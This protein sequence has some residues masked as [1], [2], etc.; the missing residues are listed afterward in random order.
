LATDLVARGLDIPAVKTVI[1]FSFPTE[2]KRYLHRVGRTARAGANGVAVTLCNDEE[3][4][5]IKKLSRKIGTQIKSYMIPPKLIT[6]AH[7]F[8]VNDVDSLLREMDLEIQQDKEM[9]KAFRDAERAANY[10]K[11]KHEIKSRPKNEW[12]STQKEKDKNKKD[13]KKEL[14][15]LKTKFD[16]NIKEKS[17]NQKVKDRKRDE[18]AKEKENKKL[19]G[20]LFTTDRETDAQVQNDENAGKKRHDLV[21]LDKKGKKRNLEEKDNANQRSGSFSKNRG[22]RKGG[23]SSF[24]KRSSATIPSKTKE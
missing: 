20:S 6:T 15:T 16:E 1:N 2:P 21:D 4:K 10:I 5:D 12:H 13:S 18:K 23:A 7:N 14:K 11:Y 19:G 9:E 22:A 8:I 24:V 3:R 17:H